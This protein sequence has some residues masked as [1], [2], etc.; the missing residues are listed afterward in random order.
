[1]TN[2]LRLP[3]LL[4]ALVALVAL[5]APAAADAKRKPPPPPPDSAADCTFVAFADVPDYLV[6]SS[7]VVGVRCDT[8]KQS[9]TV[10]PQFTR[11]GAAVSVL[12]LGDAPL[13]CTNTSQCL[14]VYDLFSLDA[15]PVAYPGDQVYCASGAGVVG[16]TTL[17]PGSACESDPRL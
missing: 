6:I 9:I 12:P 10:S 8:V 11:D 14:V 17:G 4:A 3:L 15:T 13:V 16:G 2:A 7:I 5:V 1:M